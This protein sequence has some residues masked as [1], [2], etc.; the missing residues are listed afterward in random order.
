MPVLGARRLGARRLDVRRLSLFGGCYRGMRWVS[1]G[2]RLGP[3]GW[4]SVSR[5]FWLGLGASFPVSGKGLVGKRR[6]VG[7]VSVGCLFLFGC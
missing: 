5:Q 4:L 6:V 3:V 2:I 7:L 1:S